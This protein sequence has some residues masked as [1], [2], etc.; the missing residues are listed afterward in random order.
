MLKI[1]KARYTNILY[2]PYVLWLTKR[3]SGRF[4]P[5]RF[6]YNGSFVP[7]KISKA[8]SGKIIIGGKIILSSWGFGNSPIS[9]IVGENALLNVENDF[10]IGQGT[11]I[12]AAPS[13]IINIRGKRLSSGSGITCETRIIAEKS[14]EIGYDCIIAW[15]C[16]ITDSNWHDLSGVVRCISVSIGNDVWIAH[17]VTI[18]PGAKIGDGCVVGAK[19]LLL[20]RDYLPSNLIVGNPAR[21]VRGNVKW[22]R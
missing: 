10:I 12:S 11:L 9:I 15:G 5:L 19:S 3:V 8:Q 7:V 17:D 14:I 1:R 2:L 21:P 18:L 6:V 20:G 16:T 13:S 4:L 22:S